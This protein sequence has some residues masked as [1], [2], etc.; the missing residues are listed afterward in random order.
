VGVGLITTANNGELSTK[1]FYQKV[2]RTARRLEEA[3]LD[4]LGLPRDEIEH[5]VHLALARKDFAVIGH[6][7]LRLD[8]GIH[9]YGP[10]L[11]SYDIG[12]K[13]SSVTSLNGRRFVLLAKQTGSETSLDTFVPD[14]RRDPEP[15]RFDA[16]GARQGPNASPDATP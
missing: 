3:R 10:F 1:D 4:A 15:G 12:A 7:L 2:A 14:S 9:G 5:G 13:A 16:E 11:Q 8:V 6:P